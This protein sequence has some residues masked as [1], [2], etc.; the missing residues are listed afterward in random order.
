[1]PWGETIDHKGFFFG[2]TFAEVLKL[3]VVD[4]TEFLVPPPMVRGSLKLILLS[5]THVIYGSLKLGVLP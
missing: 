5:V 1:M 3:E 2:V 4:S